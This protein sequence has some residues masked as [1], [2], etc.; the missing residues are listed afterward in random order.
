MNFAKESERR[1]VRN[2]EKSEKCC[3]GGKNETFAKQ[4]KKRN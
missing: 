2:E 3:F 4:K 1:E